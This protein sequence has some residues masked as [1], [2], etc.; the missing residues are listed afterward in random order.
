MLERRAFRVSTGEPGMNFDRALA[1]CAALVLTMLVPQYL[2]GQNTIKIAG[3][4]NNVQPGQLVRLNP[5]LETGETVLWDIDYPFDLDAEQL[6]ENASGWR[7]YKPG[8]YAH[9]PRLPLHGRSPF[10]SC[11]HLVLTPLRITFGI[12][13]SKQFPFSYRGLAPHKFTPM[14]GVPLDQSAVGSCKLKL[15]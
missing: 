15:S 8:V 13:S 11:P 1:L 10:R 12:L 3:L 6:D 7:C 5:E 14:P 9:I 4:D 2:A